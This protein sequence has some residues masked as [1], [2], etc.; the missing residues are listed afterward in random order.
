MRLRLE[1]VDVAQNGRV[2]TAVVY[3][4]Q[5]ANLH[6]PPPFLTFAD[7][8]L[9][10]R[11]SRNA[12]DWLQAS[13]GILPDSPELDW[14]R[15]LLETGS[16]KREY[17]LVMLQELVEEGRV[18]LVFSQ[19]RRMLEWIARDLVAAGIEHLMLTG[20]T[21][22]RQAVIDGFQQGAGQVFRI[23]LKA[24][25][26]GLN[27]TRADTVIFYDPWWN[28]AAESQ[29]TD[30]AYRIGQT[31]PVFVYRLLAEDTVEE[32]V[33]A[34]Q[35]R[36]RGQLEAVYTAAEQESERLRPTQHELLELLGVKG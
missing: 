15:R 14:L 35:A 10:E 25:G 9:L 2:D 22:D 31:Q 27:L 36:K 17:L 7:R 34:L 6:R 29:A 4:L 5:P 23:S 3:R 19:F 30:R 18:I 26:T 1:V 8:E 28:D 21:R 24:G 12:P 33:H 32:R 16:A 13:A 11:L 20:C